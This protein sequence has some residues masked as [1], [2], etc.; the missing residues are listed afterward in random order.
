MLKVRKMKVYIQKDQK[1]LQLKHSG[2]VQSL[3]A[4][5]KINKE[6]VIVT[7]NGALV[8]EKDNLS[9]SDEVEILQVVSGG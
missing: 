3:L 7:R 8:M 9:D 2:T 6:T 4:K 5:L 1:K